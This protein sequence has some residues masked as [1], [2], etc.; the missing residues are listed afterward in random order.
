MNTA[1]ELRDIYRDLAARAT[2]AADLLPIED[3]VAYSEDQE[4]MD[5]GMWGDGG[6]GGGGGK[7]FSSSPAASAAETAR[8]PKEYKSAEE[9]HTKQSAYHKKNNEKKA[10]ELHRKASRIHRDLVEKNYPYPGQGADARKLS[11]A[12]NK[13][14]ERAASRFSKGL[15]AAEDNTVL[16]LGMALPLGV[17]VEPPTRLMVFPL[18]EPPSNDDR[19]W[20]FTKEDLARA[21]EHFEARTEP[22]PILYDHGND[23]SKGSKAAGWVDSV[24]LAGDGLYA[25]V[26]WTEAAREA[27]RSGEWGFR[28]PGWEGE[29]DPLG[30]IYAGPLKELSLVNKP[31]IGGMSPV[32]ASSQ[33]ST[34][35]TPQPQKENPMAIDVTAAK[36]AAV[37]MDKAGVLEAVKAKYPG[38]DVFGDETLWSLIVGLNGAADPAD[39]MMPGSTTPGTPAVPFAS[40]KAEDEAKVAAAT[41]AAEIDGLKKENEALK[42]SVQEFKAREL[43]G[44]FV[45]ASAADRTSAKPKTFAERIREQRA[46][47]MGR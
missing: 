19:K 24:E 6:M 26:H 47:G 1:E 16:V 23:P 5:D 46:A 42:A 40:A 34:E 33:P 27:I 41:A 3:V 7:D 38:S 14:S 20:R 39:P 18:G 13:E 30:F 31:A 12:A 43:S 21:V 37:G 11:K 25:N 44:K 9:Y 17:G 4:R 45:N 2:A 10:E 29:E 15:P 32:H 36:K 22:M 8:T 35:P 28:S